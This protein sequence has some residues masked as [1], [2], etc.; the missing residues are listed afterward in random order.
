[1]LNVT[2]YIQKSFSENARN[3]VLG[4]LGVEKYEH[5]TFCH[6]QPSVIS[7]YSI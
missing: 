4:P 6:Q 5:Q 3:A 7:P 1:M 2:L